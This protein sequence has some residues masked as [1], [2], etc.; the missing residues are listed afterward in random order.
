MKPLKDPMIRTNP[1]KILIRSCTL[2]KEKVEPK[3]WDNKRKSVDENEK[4]K[5]LQ[6]D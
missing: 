3:P 4:A 5:G 1:T 6:K 2:N